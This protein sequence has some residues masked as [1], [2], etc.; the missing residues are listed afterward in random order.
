MTSAPSYG[1]RRL[2]PEPM[3]FSTL[4]VEA[5][6]FIISG[7]ES[8]KRFLKTCVGIVESSLRGSTISAAG[9]C[10]MES[11]SDTHEVV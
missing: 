6:S 2:E 10:V 11:G 3:L 4:E 5:S 7:Q 8:L 1:M 9:L